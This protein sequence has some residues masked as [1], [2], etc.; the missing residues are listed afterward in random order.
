MRHY[1]FVQAFLTCA[2]YLVGEVGE[3]AVIDDVFQGEA[4][5]LSDRVGLEA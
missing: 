2:D 1:S 4:G 5:G 3:V